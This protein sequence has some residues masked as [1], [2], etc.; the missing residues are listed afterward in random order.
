MEVSSSASVKSVSTEAE[1]KIL[2]KQKN[3]QEAV[4]GAI[5]EGVEASTP[6]NPAQSGQKLNIE[7]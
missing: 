1:V 6:R 4:V 3:Q 2:N 5:L 7:A